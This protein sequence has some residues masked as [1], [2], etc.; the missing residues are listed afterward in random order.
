MDG[1]W[2]SLREICIDG[3]IIDG[4]GTRLDVGM[5][6]LSEF[7][8]DCGGASCSCDDFE[9]PAQR[10]LGEICGAPLFTWLRTCAYSITVLLTDLDAGLGSTWARQIS[11]STCDDFEGP[12]QRDGL[13]KSVGHFCGHS[14]HMAVHR[15]YI[16]IP[17]TYGL[18]YF[19]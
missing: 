10:W 7:A 4:C 13:G 9:D 2:L 17:A 5:S 11:Q 3:G 18:D 1:T 6:D 15:V 12:T 14:L 8:E 19:S 16:A